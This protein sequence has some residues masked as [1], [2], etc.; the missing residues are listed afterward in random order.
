MHFYQELSRRYDQIFPVNAQEM[1]FANSL[2]AGKN[3][4]LDIGC[5][6]G[7]KTELLAAPGRAVTA[8]DQ[9]AAMIEK[10]RTEHAAPAVEYM[11]LDMRDMEKCFADGEFDAALCLGNTLVHLTEPGMLA[12]LRQTARILTADGLFV[13]QILNY[14]RILNQGIN[15]LPRIETADSVF[16]RHYEWRN[17]EMHFVTDLTT[18]GETLRNDIV[19]RPLRQGELAGMLAAAGF[20]NVDYYG[21]Y[22]GA[23]YQ[24]DSFHLIAA[25]RK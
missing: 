16:I 2:L 3:R 25:A 12:M 18:G 23:P 5:G 19:L 1:A 13:T 11:T 24:A 4:L 20:G 15:E 9:D 7:N 14:D 22:A 8:F 6:T 21:N 17:G 10:A